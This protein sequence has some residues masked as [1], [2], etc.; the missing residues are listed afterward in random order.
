MGQADRIILMINDYIYRTG[1]T[2]DGD[3]IFTRTIEVSSIAEAK[4]VTA[5]LKRLVTRGGSILYHD[6]VWTAKGGKLV[7]SD[8][9]V[10][11]GAEVAIEA[12]NDAWARNQA[13]ME[14]DW[15]R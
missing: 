8:T 14:P 11:D 10:V 7:W 4:E 12:A 2:E 13:F 15:A 9:Y 3:V 5:D 6:V 1:D